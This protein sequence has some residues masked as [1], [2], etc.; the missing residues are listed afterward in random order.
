MQQHQSKSSMLATVLTTK[1]TAEL[2][3]AWWL[4]VGDASCYASVNPHYAVTD[5]LVFRVQAV[6]CSYSITKFMLVRIGTV[7]AIVDVV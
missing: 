2:Y 5:S 1:L 3:L 4:P 6:M 7:R